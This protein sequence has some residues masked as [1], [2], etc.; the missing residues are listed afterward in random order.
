M[1]EVMTMA[2]QVKDVMSREAVAVRE[3][4]PVSRVIWTLRYFGAGAVPV[5]DAGRR[6]AGVVSEDDVLMR[7][8]APGSPSGSTA[9][10]IMTRPAL[11][12]HMD[13]PLR[14]A[15]GLMHDHRI[16]ELPV[17]DAESG[18][19]LGTL[20][21]SDLLKVFARSRTA[22]TTEIRE[23]VLPAQLGPDAAQVVATVRPSRVVA[24]HGRVPP[25]AS[26]DALVR[27]VRA[28]E[29]VVDV[30]VDVKPG[31]TQDPQPAQP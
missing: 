30:M 11:T 6:V 18:Q 25:H 22:I 8:W 24:L 14:E 9:A 21:R 1:T 20:R 27:A 29:G 19:M 16:R 26:M 10:A 4:T 3:D 23:Q 13:T 28:V 7:E 12:V 31:L 17:V 2:L 5:L 15:A